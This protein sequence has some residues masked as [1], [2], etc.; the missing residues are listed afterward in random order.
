[1]QFLLIDCKTHFRSRFFRQKLHLMGEKYNKTEDSK[2]TYL[3][4]MGEWGDVKLLA[5][6]KEFLP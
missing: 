5:L 1:M 2:L 4:F 3:A 6:E